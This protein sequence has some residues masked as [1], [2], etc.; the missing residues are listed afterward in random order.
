MYVG[1]QLNQVMI[2]NPPQLSVAVALP[3]L[4]GARLAIQLT[5]ISA[6]NVIVGGLL[7]TTLMICEQLAVFPH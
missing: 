1:T 2:T 6:G 3:V 4:V 7:S 5:V